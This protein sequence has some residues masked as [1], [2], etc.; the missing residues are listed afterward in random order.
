MK[1]NI[2]RVLITYLITIA[3]TLLVA[4][5]RGFNLNTQTGLTIGA[6][7][8][9]ILLAIYTY[10]MLRSYKSKNCSTVYPL[11]AILLGVFTIEFLPRI[12]GLDAPLF[13]IDS[14]SR[15]IGVLLGFVLITVKNTVAKW[16]YAIIIVGATFFINEY[17]FPYWHNKVECGTFSGKIPA[18]DPIQLDLFDKNGDTICL[19][20]L[21]CQYIVIYCW[22]SRIGVSRG[23]FRNLKKLYKRYKSSDNIAMF[24]AMRMQEYDTIETASQLGAELDKLSLPCVSIM[25]GTP[26]YEASEPYDNPYSYYFLIYNKAGELLYRAGKY[27]IESIMR[28]LI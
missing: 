3:V 10:F 7:V 19:D 14:L 15:V 22:G 13:L 4:C 20:S 1:N 9:M 24:A 8:A 2:N 18:S 27:R 11:L 12:C 26:L 17:G 21:D 5:I 23:Y 28:G 25:P 16:S 6:M